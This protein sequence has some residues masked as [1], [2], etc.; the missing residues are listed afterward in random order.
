MDGVVEE[1]GLWPNKPGLHASRLRA[2]LQLALSSCDCRAG[3]AHVYAPF[4]ELR[5]RW[6]LRVTDCTLA[7][8]RSWVWLRETIRLGRYILQVNEKSF[9]L[10]EGI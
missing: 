3:L 9:D 2:R 7:L 10:K 6:M 4:A 8:A 1:W 5:P